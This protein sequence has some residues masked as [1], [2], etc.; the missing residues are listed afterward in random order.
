MVHGAEVRL[1]NQS[2]GGRRSKHLIVGAILLSSGLAPTIAFADEGGVSFWL[3]GL[4]GS[5][6]AVPSPAPGWIL[7]TFGY[8]TNVHAGADVAAAREITIGRFN[9]TVNLNLSANLN[10]DID[11]VWFDPMYAFASPV[12]GGQLTVGMGTLVGQ[13]NVSLF[14]TVTASVPPF[15]IQRSDSLFSSTTGNGDLYPQAFLR[16]NKG[17]DNYMIYGTGDIPV[18]DYSSTSLANLGIGHGAADAGAGYTY[19]NPQT[20]YEFSIV[21]GFTYNLINNATQYQNGID[22]HVDWATSQFLGKQTFVGL[23][24]YVYDQITGDSG[25][26]DLVGPF[27]SRVVGIGPQIGFLFPVGEKMQGLVNVKAYGEFDAHDRPS[28]ANVWVSF[29]LTPAAAPP[30]TATPMYHK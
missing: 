12:L 11:L 17:V 9:P 27:E 22:F 30:P 21:G 24:G 16:W 10:A 28:G 20:G 13:S 23:V 29:V 3:P 18:G 1:S 15:T 14:G 2:R 8:N 6:S 19:F 25:S 4:F 7:S 5:L 26:G